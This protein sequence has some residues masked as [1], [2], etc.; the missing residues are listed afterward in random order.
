MAKKHYHQKKDRPKRLGLWE[1]TH[2]VAMHG[3]PATLRAL[4]LLLGIAVCACAIIVLVVM[5]FGPVGGTIGTIA[6]SALPKIFR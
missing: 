1:M 5:I 3:W 6:A 2:N 4:V